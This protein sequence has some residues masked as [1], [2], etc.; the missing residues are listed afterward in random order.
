MKKS[1][2]IVFL[3]LISFSA[4]SQIIR[5]GGDTKKTQDKTKTEQNDAKTSSDKTK[6][7]SKSKIDATILGLGVGAGAVISSNIVNSGAYLSNDF[8]IL[9]KIRHHRI[10]IGFGKIL[11]LTPENL[12]SLAFGQ[13]S[14][15]TVG[16]LM[17]DWMLFR[18]SPVNLGVG[19]KLGAFSNAKDSTKVDTT[20]SLANVGITAEFGSRRFS[21]FV[22]PE[23]DYKSYGQGSFHKEVSAGATLGLR[24]KFLSDTEKARLE[25]RKKRRHNR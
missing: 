21:V 11:F 13:T 15:V 4:F 22:R 24:F 2:V 23:L 7:A 9:F 20:A 19:I 16:Y 3:M 5:K 17:Y 6:S 25:E 14:N 10:G 8:D 1:V 18:W 12:G